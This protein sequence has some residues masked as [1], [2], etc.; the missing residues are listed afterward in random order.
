VLRIR[1]P[2]QMTLKAVA[3][4]SGR[5]C[6]GNHA[7]P[8]ETG[9]RAPQPLSTALVRCSI[10]EWRGGS[11]NLEAAHAKRSMAWSSRQVAPGRTTRSFSIL[12]HRPTGSRY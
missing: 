2:G 1:L 10:L 5:R 3:C 12:L 8:W 6:T 7:W 9:P 11:Q 4:W